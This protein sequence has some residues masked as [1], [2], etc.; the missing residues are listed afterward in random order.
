MIVLREIP[1]ACDTREAPPYPSACASAAAQTR[2]DR[3]FN[4]LSSIRYFR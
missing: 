4:E 3:S 1:V 2:R